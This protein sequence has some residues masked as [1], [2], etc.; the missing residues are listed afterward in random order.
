MSDPHIEE[1]QSRL[2]RRSLIKKM[3]VGAFAVPT[4][5]SFQMDSLARAGSFSKKHQEPSHSYPNQC[6]PNQQPDPHDHDHDHDPHDHDHDHD[7]PKKP[8]KPKHH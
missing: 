3:A 4:I 2:N 7:P 8:K 1:E 5:V 6:H